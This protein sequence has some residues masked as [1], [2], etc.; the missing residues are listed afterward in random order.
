[1]APTPVLVDDGSIDALDPPGDYRGSAEYRRH[2]A[3][4]LSARVREELA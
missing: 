3:A 4:V 2:L 1:V